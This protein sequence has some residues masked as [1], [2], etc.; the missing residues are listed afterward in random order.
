MKKKIIIT[1]GLLISISLFSCTLSGN[2]LDDFFKNFNLDN[3]LNKLEE[4][5][6]EGA[7]KGTTAPPPT[8][9]KQETTS[10]T[11]HKKQTKEDLFLNPTTQETKDRNQTQEI[12]LT[13]ESL[14]AFKEVMHEFISLVNAITKKVDGSSSFSLPFK[15]EFARF[16]KTVDKIAVSYG[17]MVNK[18]LYSKIIPFKQKSDEKQTTK[19][20]QQPQEWADLRKNILNAI[21][22]LKNLDQELTATIAKNQEEYFGKRV[23]EIAKTPQEEIT[24]DAT[25]LAKKNKHTRKSHKEKK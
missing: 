18:K 7:P 4:S 21:K 15:E 11:A 5:Y 25:P 24:F 13:K 19:T 1:Y 16:H 6:D 8:P 17:L 3:F 14:H 20:Q 23:Q 12:L 10:V 22:E 9:T 2:A